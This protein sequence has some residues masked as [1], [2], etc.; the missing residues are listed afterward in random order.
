MMQPGADGAELVRFHFDGVTV[1]LK[2]HR[3]ERDGIDVAAE[4]Q[5][6]DVLAYLINNRDRVVSKEELLD[7]V[8]GDRFVSES[9]LT[10]RIKSVRRCVG[11]DG[12]AQRVIRTAHGRGYQ[13]VAELHEAPTTPAS[14]RTQAESNEPKRLARVSPP[15]NATVGRED[16]LSRLAGRLAPGRVLTLVGPGGVGKTQV[17]RQAASELGDTY[18]EGCWFVE[19]AHVRDSSAVGMAILDT[20]GQPQYLDATPE[21][22]VLDSLR[23]HSG[24]LVLDNCEHV[25]EQVASLTSDLLSAAKSLSVI[26]TSRRRL[27]VAGEL[28]LDVGVLDDESSAELFANRADDHG[29]ALEA[30]LPEVRQICALL[31]NLPLAIELAC[32]Q[33]R[34]LGLQQLTALLDDRMRLLAGTTET[35]DHHQTL[36]Q[37]IS[38]SYDVLDSA[39]QE[40]L[41][42][43]SVFTGPFGLPEA[44][45]VARGDGR[46]NQVEAIQHVIELAERSLLVVNLADEGTTYRLLESVRLFAAERLDNPDEVKALHLTVFRD[47]AEQR[48]E[49][50]NGP[51]L[52]S[53][54]GE[55]LGDWDNYRAAVGY[56]LELDRLDDVARLLAA[57][58]DFAAI[59][60]RYEH[61]DWAERVIAAGDTADPR[62]ESVRAGLAR[63]MVFKDF[64][65]VVP[66]TSSL[67][68]PRTYLGALDAIAY[69]RFLGSDH[70]AGDDALQAMLDMTATTGGLRELYATG[71]AVFLRSTSEGR[72]LETPLARLRDIGE[73]HGTLGEAFVA[74]GEARRAFSVD[75]VAATIRHCGRTLELAEEHGLEILTIGAARARSMGLATHDDLA[76]VSEHLV[77]SLQ[78]YQ[79]R[80]HWTTATI[81]AVLVARVLFDSGKIDAAA[82]IL[83][84]H[85]AAGYAVTWSAEVAQPMIAAIE[86]EHPE[87][88]LAMKSGATLSGAALC[89]FCLDQ[90][91]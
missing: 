2:Q 33:T 48:Y 57:T 31:D 7:S 55:V 86:H 16:L 36:E 91:A 12:K 1:D 72:D 14:T 5:V 83:G 24:L 25:I 75:D 21:Q 52:Q 43:F 84:A 26:A 32:A 19:L 3:I 35:S 45:A 85:S 22:T 8:W 89:Q 80:G 29:I 54:F 78:R 46:L 10:S 65:R 37:A 47:S 76:M 81:E 70:D 68:D 11:D 56:A 9:A 62:L 49:R 38:T 28:V 30:D 74:L 67:E 71:I 4:P 82:T 77:D 87:Q 41:C 15:A 6:I 66:L 50:L 20:I 90:L 27:S 18:A 79:T 23:N 59:T 34:I 58:E 73:R 61:A 69:H 39:L 13:F 40:T 42:R 88:I 60:Q 63:F 53:A 44:T 17:A 64:D 51:Q